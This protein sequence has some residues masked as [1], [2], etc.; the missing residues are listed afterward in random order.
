MHQLNTFNNRKRY[1]NMNYSNNN[2][3]VNNN[4]CE[5]ICVFSKRLAYFASSEYVR[6]ICFTVRD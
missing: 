6:N 2:I 1:N 5:R 4:V 3:N